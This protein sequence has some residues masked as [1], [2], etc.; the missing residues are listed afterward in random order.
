MFSTKMY[1]TVVVFKI[2]I[3]SDWLLGYKKVQNI[4]IIIF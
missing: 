4:G 2:N 3:Q 1:N